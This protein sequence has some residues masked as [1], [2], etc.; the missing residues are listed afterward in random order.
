V[1]NVIVMA[2]ITRSAAKELQLAQGTN[3]WVLVKAITLR[4]HVFASTQQPIA[5]SAEP[6]MG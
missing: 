6:P 3:L 2:R 4:G 5:L 1:G